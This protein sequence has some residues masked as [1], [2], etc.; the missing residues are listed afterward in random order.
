MTKSA[1]VIQA[2]SALFQM[3]DPDFEKEAAGSPIRA[4]FVTSPSGGLAIDFVFRQRGEL[5]VRSFFFGE[6]LGQNVSAILAARG[7]RSTAKF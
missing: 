7:E 6:V 3:F 4:S 2:E 1:A 5:L